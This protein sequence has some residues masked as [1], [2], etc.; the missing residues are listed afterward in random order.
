MIKGLLQSVLTFSQLY[1][2]TQDISILEN[3]E[4]VPEYKEVLKLLNKFTI[5][6]LLLD[7]KTLKESFVPNAI[8]ATTIVES[9]NLSIGYFF[10]PAGM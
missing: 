2:S 4:T 7:E 9:D 1:E 6:D 8:T 3:C 5:K 10:I